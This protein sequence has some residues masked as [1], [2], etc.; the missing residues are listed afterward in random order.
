MT[1]DGTRILVIHNPVSGR[2]NAA[3]LDRVLGRM[4]ETSAQITVRETGAPGEAETMAG[5][6][7][8]F[9]VVAV[10]GGDGTVNE[11]INGLAGLGHKAP[12]LA[13]IPLGTANILAHELGLPRSASGL[14]EIVLNGERRTA[15]PGS[16]NGRRFL[17]MVSTGFDARVVAQ[18]GSGLKRC[19]GAGAYVVSAFKE[20]WRSGG[21]CRVTVDGK[22][23]ETL[24]AATVIIT[25]ARHYGGGFILAQG[26]RLGEKKLYVVCMEGSGVWNTLRYGAALLRGQLHRL[27]DVRILTG[28]SVTVEGPPGDPSESGEAG[29]AVQMDGDLAGTLPLEVCL[30]SVPVTLLA[31]PQR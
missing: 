27:G 10:A 2:R 15:W 14:A 25:R 18:V 31:P 1:T 19:L 23:G 11:A 29:G 7:R 28:I 9:D 8:G 20:M 13:F 24:D 4:R 6:A 30:D 3:R 22:D 5:E 12:P 21:R 17:L 26:A 16:A